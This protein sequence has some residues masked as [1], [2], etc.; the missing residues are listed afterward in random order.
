[1]ES[2][3][4]I[5]GSPAVGGGVVVG[6]SGGDP[7]ADGGGEPEYEEGDG[8]RASCGTKAMALKPFREHEC[9]DVTMRMADLSDRCRAGVAKAKQGLFVDKE[10]LRLS[11]DCLSIRSSRATVRVKPKTE[12]VQLW[13]FGVA[14]NEGCSDCAG[15]PWLLNEESLLGGVTA[16]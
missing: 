11:R 15:Q 1:M 9:Q 6:L 14:T 4:R 5:E 8:G 12:A 3:F 10:Q 16:R 2:P 7:A 13:W